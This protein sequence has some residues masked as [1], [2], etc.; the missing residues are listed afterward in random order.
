[1]QEYPEGHAPHE[2]EV[3][4][5]FSVPEPHCQPIPEQVFGVQG[6]Q[7]WFMQD[8]PEGHDPQ[9][10]V[11]LQLSSF[12]EPHVQPF[13]AQVSLTHRQLKQTFLT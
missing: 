11:L 3:V 13:S 5:V 6:T 9:E 10:I 8:C 2:I 1:M 7:E 12:P 4:Q